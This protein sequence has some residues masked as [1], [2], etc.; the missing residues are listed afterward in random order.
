MNSSTMS[1]QQ[2][3]PD[4]VTG[5]HAI[6]AT[7]GVFPCTVLRSDFKASCQVSA[8]TPEQENLAYRAAS[9]LVFPDFP[10]FKSP[11]AT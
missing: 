7:M 1:R 10:F 5:F 8:L 11:P 3:R 2:F 4:L 9:S 6:V